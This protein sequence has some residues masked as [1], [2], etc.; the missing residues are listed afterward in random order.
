MDVGRQIGFGF[1]LQRFNNHGPWMA[2]NKVVQGFPL[3]GG[4]KGVSG[5][6]PLP[7]A[8]DRMSSVR[9]SQD[10]DQRRGVGGRAAPPIGIQ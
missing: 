9:R 10:G 6:T 4:F 2:V 8:G 5:Q 3:A 7:L 1:C